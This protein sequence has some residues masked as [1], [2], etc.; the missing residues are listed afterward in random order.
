MLLALV[1]MA[2]ETWPPGRSTTAAAQTLEEAIG[3]I[4]VDDYVLD[5]ATM[6]TV[7]S[8]LRNPAL[9]GATAA[10]EADK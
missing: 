1:H 10:A 3:H 7:H 6:A 2:A 4:Q 5:P 9:V 8:A